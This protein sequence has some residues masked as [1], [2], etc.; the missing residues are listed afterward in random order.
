VPFIARHMNDRKAIEDV[1]INTRHLLLLFAIGLS[2]FVF[3]FAPWVQQLL[4]HTADPYHARVTALCVAVL[5]AYFLVQIYGSVLTA[6]AQFRSFITILILSVTINIT[7]NL[8]L[9][10]R[11]GA[12]ACCWSALASQYFC[13]LA[14]FITATRS[15]K[16]PFGFRSLAIYIL[17]AAVLVGFFYWAGEAFNNVWTILAISI[18]F[19]LGI[20]VTQISHFKNYFVSLR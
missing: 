9:V 8:L 19:T 4:Y 5:P 15:L 20:L 16:I 11:F 14:L 2:S 3:M 10:P 1:V 7:M 13:G 18:C 12:E 6:A 17:T